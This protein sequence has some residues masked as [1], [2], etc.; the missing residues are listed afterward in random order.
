MQAIHTVANGMG[1]KQITD[2]INNALTSLGKMSD[3][4]ELTG[5]VGVTAGDLILGIKKYE[6]ALKKSGRYNA[7]V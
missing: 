1:S 4:T 6:E 3:N 5:Y 2:L 7:S